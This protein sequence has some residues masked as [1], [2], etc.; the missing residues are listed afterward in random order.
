MPASDY[1]DNVATVAL[2]AG[3]MWG[4]LRVKSQNR[5]DEAESA[6]V[7]AQAYGLFVDKLEADNQRL[8]DEVSALRERVASLETLL[9]ERAGTPTA[10]P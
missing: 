8:R 7:L 5:R 3:G 10:H 2:G 6:K 1:L 4:W 9:R